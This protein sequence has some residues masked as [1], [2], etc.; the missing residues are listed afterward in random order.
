MDYFS[1]EYYPP[2]KY[3]PETDSNRFGTRLNTSQE[4]TSSSEYLCKEN[5]AESMENNTTPLYG[6]TDST[7]GMSKS[8]PPVLVQNVRDTMIPHYGQISTDHDLYPT[9]TGTHRDQGGMLPPYEI[10]YSAEQCTYYTPPP[11]IIHN[12]F[13]AGLNLQEEPSTSRIQGNIISKNFTPIESTE[14]DLMPLYWTQHDE[15]STSNIPY[16]NFQSMQGEF[17]QPGPYMSNGQFVSDAS[18]AA[19]NLYEEQS[20]S[21]MQENAIPQNFTPT[22]KIQDDA[23][24]PYGRKSAEEFK[25]PHLKVVRGK[26][27][28]QNKRSKPIKRKAKGGHIVKKKE[29][30]SPGKRKLENDVDCSTEKELSKEHPSRFEWSNKDMSALLNLLMERGSSEVLSENFMLHKSEQD[31]RNLLAHI[32]AASRHKDKSISRHDRKLEMLPVELWLE[33]LLFSGYEA[34]K[35]NALPQAL[36]FIAKFE[37]HASPEESNGVDYAAIYSSLAEQSIGAIPKA[38]NPPSARL[39]LDIFNKMH[40]ECDDK[41][42]ATMSIN[43]DAKKHIQR[44]SKV[45]TWQQS[46]YPRT[47]KPVLPTEEEREDLRKCVTETRSEALER[48]CQEPSINPFSFEKS[49]YNFRKQEVIEGT[50]KQEDLSVQNMMQEMQSLSKKL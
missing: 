29:N 39:L 12:V 2:G 5:T 27:I 22:S 6:V 24:L 16:A 36:N 15:Q 46:V 42:V 38:L 8:I 49:Q 30:I 28:L 37:A 1:S 44:I 14:D 43:K 25:I 13:Q 17:P 23:M 32:T 31:I 10:S 35:A 19:T 48:L 40:D 34:L 11:P 7:G 26:K 4:N 41:N 33:K 18:S 50:N 9:F 20:I 47:T 45:R 3:E 21:R